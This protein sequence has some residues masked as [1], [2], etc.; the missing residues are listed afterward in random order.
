[1]CE[2]ELN[3]LE[4]VSVLGFEAGYLEGLRKVASRRKPGE[5]LLVLFSAAPLE[6]STASR[7]GI[8]AED[9][10]GACTR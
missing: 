7:G 6:I 10:R 5:H 8:S 3:H 1:M 9:S 4:S 2:N